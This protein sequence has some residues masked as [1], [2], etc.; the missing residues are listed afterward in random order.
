M[1]KTILFF[2]LSTQLYATV[3]RGD[4]SSEKACLTKDRAMV[5]LSLP[6]DDFKQRLLLMHTLV[7]ER[8][9][10][11]FYVKP[12]KYRLMASN[13]KGCE[14]KQDITVDQANQEI[15]VRL[16]PIVMEKKP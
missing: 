15:K 6:E 13:E 3:I 1:L 9:S 7:P 8:G 14:F 4:V 11:E 10:F 2:L 16:K 5:W 12:G